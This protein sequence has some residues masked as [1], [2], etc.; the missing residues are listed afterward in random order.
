LYHH[1]T[2]A[3]LADNQHKRAMSDNMTEQAQSKVLQKAQDVLIEKEKTEQLKLN[4]AE[5]KSKREH[6]LKVLA[7]QNA[8]ATA[9]TAAATST[10]QAEMMSQLMAF[11]KK[12][13]EE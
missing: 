2:G 7:A 6:E 1:T 11:I 3:S 10:A 5:A 9:A 8:A 4:F 13:N 12:N